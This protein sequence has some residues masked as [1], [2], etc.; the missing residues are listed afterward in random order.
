MSRNEATNK[1]ARED[2]TMQRF[3]NICSDR[4]GVQTESG[5]Y[6]AEQCR[7]Q[8]LQAITVLVAPFHSSVK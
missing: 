1:V 5:L 4:L 8:E 3:R 7:L 2:M 6:L